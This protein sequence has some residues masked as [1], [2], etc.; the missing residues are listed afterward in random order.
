MITTIAIFI[1]SILGLIIISAFFSGSETALT[2]IS[3][4]R[5]RHLAD[6]GDRRAKELEKLITKQD[7]LISTLLV[8]SNLVNILASVLATSLFISLFGEAGVVIA[9]FV[10]TTLV[11]IFAEILPKMI[12]LENS[13]RWS[14]KSSFLIKIT[15]IIL[16]PVAILA[17][18]IFSIS[19]KPTVIPPDKDKKKWT[20]MVYSQGDNNLAYF[21][22]L[23]N[24]VFDAIGSNENVNIIIQT[25]YDTSRKD[26]MNSVSWYDNDIDNIT[27]G[28]TRIIVD[29]K[30]N[31]EIEIS[32]NHMSLSYKN[33]TIFSR[34]IKDSY[35]DYEK[36]IP[37]D[38][39]KTFTTNKRELIN[40]IKRVSIFSN[41]ST[42]QITLEIGNQKTTISTEDSEQAA[43]GAETITS[44]FN[45]TE[46]LKIGFNSMFILD[47]LNSIK[48]EK[49]TMFL[50]GSLNAAI[51]SETSPDKKMD[52]L[53]LLMPIRLND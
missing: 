22:M 3:K 30:E 33:T 9:T 46:N 37:L 14:L 24:K 34:I 18:K 7:T 5:I 40:A 42:K 28:V 26:F 25:D 19:E 36:V 16:G 45:N 4:A 27:S 44:Q 6:E 49:I 51:L 47:A 41:R 39:N 21:I 15:F 1:G 29:K 50:N 8:G 53:V 12:A 52:K 13:D 23:Q 31:A 10:M 20:I 43:K 2:A 17:Q 35:P 11:V 48:N 38:N 32:K